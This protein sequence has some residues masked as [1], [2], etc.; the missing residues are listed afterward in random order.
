MSNFAPSYPFFCSAYQFQL[1][2]CAFI[3]QT[4]THARLTNIHRHIQSHTT[5]THSGTQPQ[6]MESIQRRNHSIVYSQSHDPTTAFGAIPPPPTPPPA[7][8]LPASFPL[9]FLPLPVQCILPSGE[10]Q[11]D[12]FMTFFSFEALRKFY[13]IV[14]VN[15]SE[16]P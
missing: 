8:P 5:L 9:L 10:T 12:S 6:L 14:V 16:G 7:P 13:E 4:L 3:L 2:K 11:L 1:E 15:L